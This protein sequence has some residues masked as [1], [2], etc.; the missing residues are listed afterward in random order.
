MSNI[1]REYLDTRELAEWLG[2]SV[3]TVVNLRQR[4]VLPY[5]KFGRVVRFN[6]EAVEAALKEFTIEGIRATPQK[7][8]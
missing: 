8:Q 5:V 6:R 7:Y 1:T 2:I 3:R 4:H